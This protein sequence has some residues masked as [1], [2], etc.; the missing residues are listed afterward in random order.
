MKI[1]F[2]LCSITGILSFLLGRCSLEITVVSDFKALHVAVFVLMIACLARGI[3]D[4]SMI[5]K[6]AKKWFKYVSACFISQVDPLKFC[7]DIDIA[8][9]I[10]DGKVASS[11]LESLLGDCMRAVKV[12]RLYFEIV[13]RKKIGL[14]PVEGC[15]YERVL[16]ANCEIVIGNVP[17]PVGLVGPLIVNGKVVYVPVATT[18]GCLVASTN[19]GCKAISLSFGC[20]TEILKDGISRSPCVCL[21]SAMRAAEVKFWLDKA[22]NFEDLKKIFDSTSAY[23]RLMSIHSTVAGRNL[24]IRFCCSSGDAM[25]MNIVSKGCLKAMEYLQ[26]IFPDMILVTLSSNTCS[27]KKSAASNWIMGRGKSVVA[28]AVISDDVVRSVLKSSIPEMIETC[29]KKCIIGSQL[30]GALCG[31]NAHAANVI[32]GIFLATGQVMC[33]HS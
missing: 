25:G 9:M 14:L 11:K 7:S 17:I 6:A 15:D 30:A 32:T 33:F 5:Y 19:R 21:P 1:I 13:M 31:Y 18:E 16:G 10:V 28:E 4:W 2:L 27:D 12:R 22:H 3:R 23:G 26:Q 29:H 8:V 20:Q 24:Y